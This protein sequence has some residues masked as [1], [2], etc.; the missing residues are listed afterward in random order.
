MDLHPSNKNKSHVGHC[1]YN[2]HVRQM[3]MLTF[4]VDIRSDHI[5]IQIARPPMEREA[6]P[7]TRPAP[8]LGLRARRWA[9]G[10]RWKESFWDLNLEWT[11]SYW[12]QNLIFPRKLDHILPHSKDHSKDHS[13]LPRSDLC[14]FTLTRTFSGLY[15]LLLIAVYMAV[16]VNKLVSSPMHAPEMEVTVTRQRPESVNILPARCPPS[17]STSTWSPVSSCSTSSSTWPP[18]ECHVSSVTCHVSRVTCPDPPPTTTCG[19]TGAGS[20][21]RARWCSGWGASATTS[22]SSRPT[23]SW[24]CTPTA[25][26]WST[27]S[28]ASSPSSSSCSRP[29]SS[30]SIPGKGH[31]TY[32]REKIRFHPIFHPKIS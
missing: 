29:P 21:G 14:L 11:K 20:C 13:Y 6:D 12:R 4:F 32:T 2:L 22:S 18:G 30:S 26:T 23:S 8:S 24:T 27:P 1:V 25:W 7:A 19:R 28:T 5:Y 17:C 16:T 10:L 31:R 3:T 9:A 15:C